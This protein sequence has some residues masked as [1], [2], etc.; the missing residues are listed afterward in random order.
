MGADLTG[1]KMDLMTTGGTGGSAAFGSRTGA[2]GCTL[3][4]DTS[5][6]S[7]VDGGVVPPISSGM[8]SQLTLGR[9]KIYCTVF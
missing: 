7:C 9:E 4:A 2:G 3:S 6:G 5:T 1:T 8:A